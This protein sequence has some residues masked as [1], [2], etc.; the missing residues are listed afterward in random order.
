[1]RPASPRSSTR[2]RNAGTRPHTTSGTI[3][4]T[5]RGLV[6][7]R[8]LG[9]VLVCRDLDVEQSSQ[10]LF[11]LV[12]E[13]VFFLD[14]I[15]APCQCVTPRRGGSTEAGS[16]SPV[17]RLAAAST[18]C[19]PPA[20]D[21]S[22]VVPGKKSA[23]RSAGRPRWNVALETSQSRLASQT[24]PSLAAWPYTWRSSWL[25]LRQ[26]QWPVM[27]PREGSG[28][29]GVGDICEVL[30]L[31]DNVDRSASVLDAADK[32]EEQKDVENRLKTLV[33]VDSLKQRLSITNTVQ[34]PTEPLEHRAIRPLT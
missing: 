12:G 21:G 30:L 22:R 3:Q 24:R 18:G 7:I 19:G 29:D 32:I 5:Q 33:H 17:N 15:T 2:T 26:P 20:R 23:R 9:N 25:A 16:R 34:H 8:N 4:R 6:M 1:M 10:S 31:V 11:H 14:L 28:S 27:V 13:H